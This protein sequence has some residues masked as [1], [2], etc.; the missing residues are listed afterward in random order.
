MEN[1]AGLIALIVPCYNE[2]SRLNIQDFRAFAAQSPGVHLL[3][4]DDGSRDKTLA[5]LETVRAGNEGTIS[6]LP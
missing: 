3:F 4:V 2:A 1:S 6:I 5:I